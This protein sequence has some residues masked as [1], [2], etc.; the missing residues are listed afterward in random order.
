MQRM[1]LDQKAEEEELSLDPFL[2]VSLSTLPRNPT[3]HNLP[4]T[5]LVIAGRMTEADCA[6]DSISSPTT[7]STASSRRPCISAALGNPFT[8]ILGRSRAMHETDDQQ[9]GR[10]EVKEGTCVLNLRQARH[11]A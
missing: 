8:A 10:E 6:A 9:T 7:V 2:S 3:C 11:H 1:T 4:P 5:C